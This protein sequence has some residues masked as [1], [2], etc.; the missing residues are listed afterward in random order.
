MKAL[1]ASGGTKVKIDLVRSIT[2]MSRGTFGSQICDSFWRK[3]ITSFDATER[4][5][6]SRKVLVY[7]VVKVMKPI[8]LQTSSLNCL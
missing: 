3:L 8:M 2:N 4:L 5:R 7:A 1:I 6:L